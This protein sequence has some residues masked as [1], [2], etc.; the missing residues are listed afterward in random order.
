ME[1]SVMFCHENI[2]EHSLSFFGEDEFAIKRDAN[3]GGQS[4]IVTHKTNN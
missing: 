2:L 3:N 1:G 4:N